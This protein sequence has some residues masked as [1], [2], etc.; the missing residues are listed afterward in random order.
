MAGEPVRWRV[1]GFDARQTL[2]PRAAYHWD[3]HRRPAPAAVA[4]LTLQG[5][6]HYRDQQGI[7]HVV[8]PDRLLLF[9]HCESTSY[10]LPAQRTETYRCAW[11]VLVGAGLVEQ[12]NDVRRRFGSIHD[13]KRTGLHH[14][15][16]RLLDAARAPDPLTQTEGVHRFVLDLFRLCEEAHLREQTPVRRAVEVIRRDPCRPWS[17]K[18]VADDHGCTREH[19]TRVFTDTVGE[20]PGAYLAAARLARALEL[21]TQSALPLPAVAAQSGYAAL[22]TMARHVRAATGQSPSALR[23]A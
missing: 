11:C 19:L 21:I 3:N 17:L 23:D 14:A 22:H 6:L 4:Q 7:E 12:V 20:P 8:G 15:M 18:Q 1:T 16:R 13:A 9:N 5:R 2:S 10:F